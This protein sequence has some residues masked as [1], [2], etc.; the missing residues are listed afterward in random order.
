MQY[1]LLNGRRFVPN[2]D[3]LSYNQPQAS[4]DRGDQ[5]YRSPGSE[6]QPV[7]SG[8]SSEYMTT[9]SLK[10]AENSTVDVTSFN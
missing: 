4:F 5:V 7:A 3:V 9:R 8:Q 10:I 6:E 2:T 1:V